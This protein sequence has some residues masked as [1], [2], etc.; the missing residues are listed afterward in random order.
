MSR[1]T[2]Y[3]VFIFLAFALMLTG[4]WRGDKESPRL[5]RIAPNPLGCT[6]TQELKPKS[7]LASWCPTFGR[8]YRCADRV[9]VVTQAVDKDDPQ[10]CIRVQVAQLTIGTGV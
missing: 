9:L 7:E 2:R 1:D 5:P 8:I 3:G 10:I 4:A 6:L